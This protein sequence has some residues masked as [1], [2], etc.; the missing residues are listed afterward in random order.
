M[1][2]TKHIAQRFT[3]ENASYKNLLVYQKA[4]TLTVDISRY[5]SGFRLPKSKEFL[6]IQLL[7]AVSSIGANIAEGYGRYYDKRS[8]SQALLMVKIIDSFCLLQEVPVLK[9]SIGLS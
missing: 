1:Q 3:N 8:L 7:R 5:F 4:K 2:R 6:I 9:P